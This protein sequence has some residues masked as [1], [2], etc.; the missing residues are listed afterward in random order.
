MLLVSLLIGLYLFSLFLEGCL[1][2]N[3]LQY[4]TGH[5][6]SR[7]FLVLLMGYAFISVVPF[8]V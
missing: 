1:F 5:R 2:Y 8:F 3:L 7:S 6:G 4:S